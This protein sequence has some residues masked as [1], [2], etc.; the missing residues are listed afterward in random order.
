V[1]DWTQNISNTVSVF[2]GATT[3]KWNSFNWGEAN[4]GEGT[5]DLE[6]HVGKLIVNSQPSTTAVATT[7]GKNLANSIAPTFE[8]SE[9]TLTDGSGYN[10][11][12]KRPSTDAEDRTNP[13]WSE[14]D[15]GTASWSC[16]AAGSTTWSSA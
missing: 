10:Y 5:E 15:D 7:I 11:I 3:T 2:W 1:A 4:W 16:Q 13:T 14:D 9:E 6:V 8:M 12:F